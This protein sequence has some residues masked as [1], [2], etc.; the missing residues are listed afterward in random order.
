MN[1][2]QTPKMELA[3]FAMMTRHSHCM[4]FRQYACR[5][6]IYLRFNSIPGVTPFVIRPRDSF[7]EETLKR[8]RE[9]GGLLIR[10]YDPKHVKL[11]IPDCGA[12]MFPETPLQY[13]FLESYVP[14]SVKEVICYRPPSW[15]LHEETVPY[16]YPTSEQHKAIIS[17]IDAFIGRELTPRLQAALNLSKSDPA[18]TAVFEP[19]EMESITGIHERQMRP[20]LNMASLKV[21]RERYH[22]YVPTIRPDN[23][24]QQEFYDRV[25]ALP[26]MHR[27]ERMMRY[28]MFPG[29][30]RLD[31]QTRIMRLLVKQGNLVR[32][33]HIYVVRRLA[34]PDY[35]VIDGIANARRADWAKI[36]EAVDAAPVYPL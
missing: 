30:V 25:V 13:R 36:R 9:T 33:P 18:T 34:A 15:K 29:N 21:Y 23:P 6:K 31:G 27:G 32:K 1:L 17:V 5:K 12:M 10:T 7:H 35:T 2:Y 28:D 24:D 22:C 26:E 16:K 3:I 8:W 11:D 4:V 19:S 14:E 20:I